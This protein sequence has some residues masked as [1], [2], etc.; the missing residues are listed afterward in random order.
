MAKPGP[1]KRDFVEQPP[2]IFSLQLR[3]LQYLKDYWRWVTAGL[4][5]VF[6]GLA[7]WG[8]M[9]QLKARKAEQAGAAMT[10]AMPLLSK[11]EAAAEALKA[12][13]QILKDY[14]GTP[15]AREA[16]M[17]RAHLLYQKRDYG[18][19]AKAY[20][21]LQAGPPS[22][23]DP[24]IAESL[25]YCYEA[26]GDYRQAIDALQ[27]VAEKAPAPLQGE[28]FRRLAMLLE[29]SGKPQEAA[30]YWQKLLEKSPD[31]ALLPYI[32][33]KLAAADA[34][35]QKIIHHKDTKDTK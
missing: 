19:A 2:E 21:A 27:P 10:K 17:F 35:S 14:P 13:D 22:S 23:W 29:L 25:S 32:K 6:L 28:I 7:V 9:T 18:E 24:L 31:P 4:V 26:R 30:P 12:L 5:A 1:R 34:A 3:L 33:E 16:A 11:P 8:I 20:E 15:T